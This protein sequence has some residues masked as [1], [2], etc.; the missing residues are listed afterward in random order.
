MSNSNEKTVKAAT[1][2]M[3]ITLIGKILGLVRDTLLASN[4]GISMEA[5]AFLTASR[6]PRVF[7][8]AIFASAISASFIPIF[9]ENLEKKGKDSAFGFSNKFITLIGLV[10]V[11][12]TFVGLVF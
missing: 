1:G 10:T 6:I 2:M 5:N 3:L 8:D 11:I 12:M 9:N 7:F 4:Y